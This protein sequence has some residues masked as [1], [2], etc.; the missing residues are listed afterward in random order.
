M[1]DPVTG[2][3][4][5]FSG[6]RAYSLSG[7]LRQDLIAQRWAWGVEADYVDEARDFGLD[8]IEIDDRGLDLDLF[9]ETTRFWGVKMQL[10][11]INLLDREFLRDRRLFDGPRTEDANLSL[12][13][14]RD[15]RRGRTL[16]FNVSG[17]F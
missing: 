8:E 9:V 5:R 13:E 7:E 14:L 3:A 10:S 12:R 1:T 2:R 6:Q 11:A 15:R 17:T 4:R 16:V